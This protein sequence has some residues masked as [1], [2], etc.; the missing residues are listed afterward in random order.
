MSAHEH[1]PDLDRA[2]RAVRDRFDGT[3]PEPDATLRRALLA[4]RKTARR[5]RVMRW[6]VLPLAA[7]LAASTA[8]ASA[9]GRLAPVISTVLETLHADR[10]E[11]APPPPVISVAPAPVAPAPAPEPVI[12]EPVTPEPVTPEPVAL[13]EP[14]LLAKAKAV[15]RYAPRPVATAEV[16]TMAASAFPLPSVAPAADPNAALFAEAHRLHF[17][18]RDPARALAAWDR[19]LAAAPTGKFAHEARYNRA[20]SLVRVGRHSEAK[21]ELLAFANGAYG[22]YRREE[23]RALLEALAR[24]E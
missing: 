6:V 4:T 2:F 21:Q 15:E 12:P 7:A 18:E 13:P 16:A 3:H 14:S 5:R 8:W 22:D 23:A 9:T 17:T 1:H 11:P 10:A 20:L 19:Y 24:D